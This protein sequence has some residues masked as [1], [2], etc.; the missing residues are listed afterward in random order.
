MAR[1]IIIISVAI[2]YSGV[3]FEMPRATAEVIARIRLLNEPEFLSQSAV[4]C[5]LLE[6]VLILLTSTNGALFLVMLML[7]Q[8]NTVLSDLW[9]MWIYPADLF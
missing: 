5:C 8:Q 1:I 7:K 4:P 6:S 2:G 9:T 3:T